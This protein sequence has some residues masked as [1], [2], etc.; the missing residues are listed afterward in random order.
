MFESSSHLACHHL[1]P[2]LWL[3]LANVSDLSTKRKYSTSPR[4][5]SP[6]THLSSQTVFPSKC[7]LAG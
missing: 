4:S 5:Y 3:T 2:V 1:M 7:L 6:V